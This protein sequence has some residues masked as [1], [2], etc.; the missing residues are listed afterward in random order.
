MWQIK[1]DGEN[2]G[3]HLYNIQRTVGNE[4]RIFGYRKE[5]CIISRLR[6]GHTALD[7]YL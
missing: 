1:W 6:I 5:D 2:K 7:H 4:R 3:Q